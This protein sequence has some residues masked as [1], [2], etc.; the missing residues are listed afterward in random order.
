MNDCQQLEL[1]DRYCE[2]ITL[3][4]ASAC[5]LTDLLTLNE[6]LHGELDG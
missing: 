5:R 6:Y 1:K 3:W 4:L 2:T